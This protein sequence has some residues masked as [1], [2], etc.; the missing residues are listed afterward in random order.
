MSG[1]SR[2]NHSISNTAPSNPAV[3]DEWYNPATKVLYKRSVTSA[4]AVQWI[5]TIPTDNTATPANDQL[6]AWSVANSQWYPANGQSLLLFANNLSSTAATL[7]VQEVATTSASAATGTINFDV[8]T[9]SVLYYTASASANWTL[10]VRGSSAATLDS[11]MTTGQS[12][13]IVFLATQ[14]AT[15]Y[16]SNSF[17][18]DSAAVTPKYQGGTAWSSGN[19]SG[20][21][22][23]FY[24]IIKT[25][26]AAFTVLA[27]QTQFK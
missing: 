26:S 16:Y 20:I 1:F 8:G 11:I 23:Y 14:G 19:A 24:T 21:D 25:G 22:A 5:Q 9:Q 7:S 27:S 15:A 13:S 2:F 3:G 17:T 12:A 4:G 18:I 6:L 10:N